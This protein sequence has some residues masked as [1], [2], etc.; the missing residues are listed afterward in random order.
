MSL[1]S[2]PAWP[3]AASQARK[4]AP[5]RRVTS[6][7]RVDALSARLAHAGEVAHTLGLVAERGRGEL[8]PARRG[9]QFT[10]LIRV[11]PPA[12]TVAAAAARYHVT[13]PLPDRQGAEAA[14][15][16]GVRYR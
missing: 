7:P 11:P 9:L 4:N 15:P 6:P 1:S 5:G 10:R 14:A 16:A 12:S 13:S 2:L 3:E 8:L